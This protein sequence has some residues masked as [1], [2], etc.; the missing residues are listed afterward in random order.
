MSLQAR[1]PSLRRWVAALPCAE[2][3][4]GPLRAPS[5]PRQMHFLSRRQWRVARG[6]LVR[7]DWGRNDLDILCLYIH[8]TEA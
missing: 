8:F 6:S 7:S 2:T 4:M 1:S 5:P 3:A